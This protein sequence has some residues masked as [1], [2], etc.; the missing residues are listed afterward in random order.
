MD[1]L[2]HS[3]DIID[4]NEMRFFILFLTF[5]SELKGKALECFLS[6][7]SVLRIL[8]IERQSNIFANIQFNHNS[9]WALPLATVLS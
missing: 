7:L 4:L 1:T 9:C 2:C 5:S 8:L 6:N 3:T